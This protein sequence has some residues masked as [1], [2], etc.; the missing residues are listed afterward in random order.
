M[1]TSYGGVQPRLLRRDTERRWLAGL[2]AGIARR[3][4]FDVALVRLAFVVAAAAGGLGV[5]AYGLGWLVVPAGEAE[6]GARRRAPA[7]RGAVQVAL[8][9]GLLLLSVLLTFRA[10]GIWFSDALVWP[11]VLVASGGALIWRASQENEP[12]PSE[13]PPTVALSEPAPGRGRAA[14]ESG[15]DGRAGTDGAGG[16]RRGRRRRLA[17]G[18]GGG[19]GGGC[20][21]RLPAGH[22]RARRRTGRAARRDRRGRGAGGDLRPL[23]PAPRAL[24]DGRACRA[25]PLPGAR[26]GGRA[27]ARLRPA[28]ARPGPAPG[29]RPAG[30]GGAGPAPGARAARLARR[31]ARPPARWPVWAPHSRRPQPRWRSTTA[32]RWRW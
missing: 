16:R 9:T 2:C 24:A 3:Y 28:D 20:R 1:T 18:C 7:G 5:V 6:A 32:F 8:G 26:R 13:R 10:L 19:P 12:Q 23:D 25:H 11:L 14:E 29:R 21:H 4:G 22:R 31:A 17:N 30:G 15:G 27:P